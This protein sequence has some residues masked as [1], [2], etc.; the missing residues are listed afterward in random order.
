MH[1]GINILDVCV[2]GMSARLPLLDHPLAASASIGGQICTQST[3][4]TPAGKAAMYEASLMS[5]YLT[6][7][8]GM[9]VLVFIILIRHHKF[10]IRMVN[11]YWC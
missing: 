2:P 9:R 1:K 4:L 7:G 6:S 3:R 8:V 5:F 10:T 11:A